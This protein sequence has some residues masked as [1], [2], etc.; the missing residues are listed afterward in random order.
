MNGSKRS[1]VTQRKQALEQNDA[2]WIDESLDHFMRSEE[3]L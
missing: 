1:L 3:G 2:L